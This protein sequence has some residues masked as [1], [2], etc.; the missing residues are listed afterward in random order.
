MLRIGLQRDQSAEARILGLLLV[1][2]PRK[3]FLGLAKAF[4]AEGRRFKGVYRSYLAGQFKAGGSK[5]SNA[6][7]VYTRGNK[8]EDLR[9]GVFTRW[10]AA[11]IYET[12][13][14]IHAAPGRWLA[15]PVLKSAYT[16][17]GRVK[18]SWRNEDG[19]WKQELFEG[20]FPV[21]VRSGYLLCRSRAGRVEAVWMLIRQTR[22]RAVLNF[23]AQVERE[24][25]NRAAKFQAALNLAIA[26]AAREAH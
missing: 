15:F 13:G 25:P 19:S 8:L 24:S 5:V 11:P 2:M 26:R 3:V 12:G 4:Y 14:V 9:L 20:L 22:R 16:A 18:R 17:R 6:F 10:V 21:K 23:F 1:D 7:R